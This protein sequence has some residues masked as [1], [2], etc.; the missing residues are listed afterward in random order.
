MYKICDVMDY[1]FVIVYLFSSIGDL[2]FGGVGE[3]LKEVIDVFNDFNEQY[4]GEIIMLQF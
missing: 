3:I 1:E 2:K 4:F